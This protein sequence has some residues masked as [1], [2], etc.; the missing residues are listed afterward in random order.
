M[1]LFTRV[2]SSLILAH[3]RDIFIKNSTFVD[4]AAGEGSKE[5]ARRRFVIIRHTHG[6]M[7]S[8]FESQT[9]E[10]IHQTYP[11]RVSALLAIKFLEKNT[12]RYVWSS[13]KIEKVT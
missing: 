12:Q 13:E 11:R 8:I 9:T 2:N 10:K 3:E 4:V 7:L 6:D 1:L 5:T